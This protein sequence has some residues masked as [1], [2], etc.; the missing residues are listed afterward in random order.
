MW[1]IHRE[2]TSSPSTPPWS[3]ELWRADPWLQLF[4]RTTL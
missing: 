2:Q 1:Q 3:P 4:V